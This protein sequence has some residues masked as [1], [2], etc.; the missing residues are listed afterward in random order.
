MKIN[1][2]VIRRK[3]IIAQKL[4][5]DFESK[6]LNFQRF[7][8]KQHKKHNYLYSNIG[9]MHETLMVFDMVGNRTESSKSDKPI[10][11]KTKDQKRNQFIVVL[12]CMADDTN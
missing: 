12:S 10:L 2:F 3:T 6:I 1:N 5:E 11:M 7:V 8:I 9:N 4:Q